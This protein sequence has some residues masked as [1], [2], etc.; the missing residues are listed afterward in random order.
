M[1]TLNNFIS[2]FMSSN[3]PEEQNNEKK[4]EQLVFYDFETTGLNPFYNKIIEYAF[5]K[6]K[7]P[8]DYISSLIDPETKFES[9]ITQIT[10]I[11]PDDLND[12]PT[13]KSLS[14]IIDSDFPSNLLFEV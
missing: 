13:I 1:D 11:H 12:K 2:N 6:D 9:K 5:M 3:N 10:G 7:E 4:Y 14:S 8:E